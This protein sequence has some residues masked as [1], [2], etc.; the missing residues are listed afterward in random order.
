MIHARAAV[1]QYMVRDRQRMTMCVF[2]P[3]R[4]TMTTGRLEP[5]R[6]SAG[7]VYVGHVRGYAVAASERDGVGYALASDLSDD[8]SARLLVMAR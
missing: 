5:R 6:T 2:D 4:V 3:K 8:E 1:L 7:M